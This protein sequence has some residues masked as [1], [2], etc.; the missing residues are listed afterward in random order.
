MA[1]PIPRYRDR[2]LDNAQTGK[3]GHA[4]TPRL[5]RLRLL[6][7]AP[8]ARLDDVVVGHAAL[9]AP[10]LRSYAAALDRGSQAGAQRSAGDPDRIRTDDLHLDRV[11]C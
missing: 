3:S 10:D 6:G 4:K 11:A 7:F 1:T 2:R 8:F 9:A 5:R